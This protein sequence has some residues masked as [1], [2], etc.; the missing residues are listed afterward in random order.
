VI[1]QPAS[2]LAVGFDLDMTLI[3]SSA[4]IRASLTALVAE[5][6][7]RID[8]EAVLARIGPKLETELARWFPSERITEAAAIYRRHYAELGTTDLVALPGA[9]DAVT[10]VRELGGRVLV[11]TAKT[12]NMAEMCLA[13]VGIEADLVAGW[14]H[15][16]EKG[17][18]LAAEGAVHYVGDTDGDMVAAVGAGATPVAVLTGPHSERELRDA[19]ATVV[20]ADLTQFRAWLHSTR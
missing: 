6:G 13:H 11:V 15:G 20:L 10:A 12:T 8:V 4:G 9:L 18:V 2:S 7:V 5:T 16:A 1:D 3:D 17:A 14:L 19:G